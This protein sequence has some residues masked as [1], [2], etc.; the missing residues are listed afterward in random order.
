MT[1]QLRAD[2]YF[3]IAN[4]RVVLLDLKADR[5]FGL[6]LKADAAFQKLAAGHHMDEADLEA[7]EPFVRN[8]L[9]QAGSEKVNEPKRPPLV[10]PTS[11]AVDAVSGSGGLLPMIE[12]VA[13]RLR[14]TKSLKRHSL[15]AAITDIQQRK[16]SQASQN[17]P[18]YD[19]IAPTLGAFLLTR[20]LMPTHDRCL[21]W[22]IAMAD[23]LS[24]R[25]CFP[26]LVIGVKMKPFAAHAWIQLE[27]RVLSDRLD[28]V[29]PYTPIL[30]V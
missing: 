23:Y 26:D 30:V 1:L 3:C 28:E 13:I 16:A 11:S 7:L 18:S 20:R 22:S 5:Y 6:P 2:T 17:N 12:A 21:P 4:H 24:R 10:A 8:G 15:H 27:D 19:M 25:R 9:L 29:L 14:A